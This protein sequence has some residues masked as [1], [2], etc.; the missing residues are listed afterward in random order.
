GAGGRARQERRREDREDERP[1]HTSIIS[2]AGPLIPVKRGTTSRTS[3][4]AQKAMSSSSPGGPY[5]RAFR[6]SS[7]VGNAL[8]TSSAASPA[9]VRSPLTSWTMRPAQY[10]S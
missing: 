8:A 3:S 2:A 6:P 10:A 7:A 4:R 9:S 5:V 1:P